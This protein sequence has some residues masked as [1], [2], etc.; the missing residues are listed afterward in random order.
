[1]KLTKKSLAVVERRSI[2]PKQIT[3]R[4]NP[5]HSVANNAKLGAGKK[6]IKK[7]KWK[8]QPMYCLTLEERKTCDS[9]CKMW[10]TCYGNNMYLAK[11][12]VHGDKLVK[13]ITNQLKELNTKHKQGFVVRLHVLGDFYSISY[14]AFWAK[15]MEKYPNMTVFGYTARLQGDMFTALKKLRYKYLDRWFIR[16]SDNKKGRG[17]L[18]YASDDKGKKGFLCPQTSG[19]TKACITCMACLSSKHTV[20]FPTH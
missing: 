15:M 4:S 12:Y 10:L 17:K 2:F 14:I 16:F 11:R 3:S 9:M 5:L 19:T 20:W 13:D 18:I 7:G 8:G 1:M 6:I